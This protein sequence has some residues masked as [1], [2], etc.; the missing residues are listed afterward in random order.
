MD[1]S[2]KND[3]EEALD[4]M[5]K[6]MNENGVIDYE[7]LKQMEKKGITPLQVVDHT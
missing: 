6:V 1:K 2:I 3:E 5:E 7:K 4:K